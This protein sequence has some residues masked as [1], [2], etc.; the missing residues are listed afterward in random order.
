MGE[1]LME[2]V[3]EREESVLGLLSNT[4]FC[5]C[6]EE[7]TSMAPISDKEFYSGLTLVGAAIL[8]FGLVVRLFG[9]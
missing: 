3:K 8:A 2:T 7:F 6:G 9:V 5:Q 1:I 4:L